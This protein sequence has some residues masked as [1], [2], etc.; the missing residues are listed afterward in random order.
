MKKAILYGILLA[1]VFAGCSSAK[2]SMLK[3][4]Y[5]S[6]IRKS[7]KKLKKKPDSYKYVDILETSFNKA[8][9]RDNERIDYLRKEGTPDIWDDIFNIYSRMKRRQEVVKTLPN[10][11]RG[12][13]LVNYDDE[14]ITAKKKAAEFFYVHGKSML[15]KGGRENG[16]KAY[17]DFVKVKKYYG[18]YKDVD[19]QM[20]NARFE[21]TSNAIFKMQNNSG[22]IIHEGFQRE[23]LRIT[24]ADLGG[25]WLQYYL[26][27]QQ[28]LYFDYTIALKLKTI[29]VSPESIKERARIERKKVRDGWEY[30]LD[31]NGNVMK[32]SL[33]NDIKIPKYKEISCEVIEVTQEKESV[34]GGVIEYRNNRTGQLI[35]SEPLQAQNHF[36]HLSIRTNGDLDALNEDTKKLVGTQPVPF[37]PDPDMILQT[38]AVLKDVTREA[39][40]RNK[41]IL[42]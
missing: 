25:K 17:Y 22:L 34:V 20:N 16:R 10:I 2:K 27:E 36:Y 1:V 5:D 33:G 32:D 18:E 4:N 19:N 21:G 24:V 42:Y 9:Q 38:A 8:N 35:K 14:I 11:P 15:E 23:L 39:L 26:N 31:D 3:G 29:V 41:K 30:V 12:I 28:G 6:A 13:T 7:V 40:V 37:P